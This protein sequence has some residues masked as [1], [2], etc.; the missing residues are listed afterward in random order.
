MHTIPEFLFILWLILCPGSLFL[1]IIICLIE[2]FFMLGWN[3]KYYSRGILFYRKRLRISS[4]QM[5]DALNGFKTHK[6]VDL[7]LVRKIVS[8][9]WLRGTIET[10]SGNEFIINFKCPYCIFCLVLFFTSAPLLSGFQGNWQDV[11]LFYGYI[12][13]FIVFILLFY[14]TAWLYLK[15][16]FK[17]YEA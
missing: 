8:N 11:P 15:V 16:T 6:L 14:C 9:I 7:I 17:K 13:I 3:K 4:Y 12:L 5:N 1:G 10:K 2:V